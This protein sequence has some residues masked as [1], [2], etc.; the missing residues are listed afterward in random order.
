MFTPVEDAALLQG[1]RK[2]GNAWS[3]LQVDQVLSS[4]T[5]TDLRDRFRIRYPDE[6]RSAGLT[7]KPNTTIKTRVDAGTSPSS[8]DL[9]CQDPYTSSQTSQTKGLPSISSDIQPE[10]LHG[11]D[12][13]WL[14]GLRFPDVEDDGDTDPIVLD[15]S[16]MDWADKNLPSLSSSRIPPFNEVGDA[17]EIDPLAAFT[18]V[19]TLVDP[20][21]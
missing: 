3:L 18:N 14:E 21:K 17:S 8:N 10:L 12:D 4:R 11:L 6:Y 19:R 5:S 2:Y 13:S 7:T 9:R 15:R 16:I 20:F 1:F